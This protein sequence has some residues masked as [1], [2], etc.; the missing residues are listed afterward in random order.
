MKKK[1]LVIDKHQFGYLVDTYKWVASLANEYD[2][3]LVCMDMQAEKYYVDGV[4][5]KYLPIIHNRYIRGILFI[6]F[7]VWELVNFEGAIIVSYFERCSILKKIFPRKKMLLDVRTLSISSSLAVR[8]KQN[9]QIRNA[10]LRYKVVS[11]VS[12]GIRDALELPLSLDTYIIPLG[13]DCISNTTKEYD[14]M[15][16]LYIGTLSGRD[17]HK[18]ILGLYEFI[19][20]YPERTITYDIIGDGFNGELL[21]LKEL[22][23]KMGLHNVITLHGYVPHFKLKPFFDKCNIGVAFVPMRE[24]YEHQPSTK[25]FEYAFSGLYTIATS[26]K[27]NQELIDENNGM[28]ITDVQSDFTDALIEISKRTRIISEEV[29]RQSLIEYSWDTLIKT[30]LLP[31]IKNI[32]SIY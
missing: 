5:I 15:R 13:A 7:A 10:C 24:C 27:A 16:L 2:I 3:T 21:Q 8:E 20:R 1:L 29:I 4:K 17:V 18:T 25:I 23:D 32:E 30:N 28:L 6:L 31:I 19:Q 22:V 26:T 12:R 11:F 9:K 14:P